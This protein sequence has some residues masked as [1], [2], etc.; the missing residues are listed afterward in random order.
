MF[1]NS[2]KVLFWNI[3]T[4]HVIVSKGSLDFGFLKNFID[5]KECGIM[6]HL[7]SKIFHLKIKTMKNFVFI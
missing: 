2:I 7:R 1:V 5:T 3:N 4:S 6:M